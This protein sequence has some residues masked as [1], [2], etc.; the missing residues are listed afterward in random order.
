M[1]LVHPIDSP[2][3]GRRPCLTRGKPP[4][5]A[6]FERRP[7]ALWHF[8]KV[9]R[10]HPQ[11]TGPRKDTYPATQ[12]TG[13]PSQLS[14][15]ARLCRDLRLLTA[16][17]ELTTSTQLGISHQTNAGSVRKSSSVFLIRMHAMG[18]T[19][20]LAKRLASLKGYLALHVSIA[21]FTTQQGAFATCLGTSSGCRPTPRGSQYHFRRHSQKCCFKFYNMSK[22]VPNTQGQSAG[23][24]AKLASC[25]TA[26]HSLGVQGHRNTSTRLRRTCW[27]TN[28][29]GSPS[30]WLCSSGGCT[31]AQQRTGK[32]K[33]CWFP[34]CYLKVAR[35]HVRPRTLL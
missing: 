32:A 1:P 20:S 4:C 21:S 12:H 16:S 11:S 5:L 10:L 6:A 14:S 31:R 34:T 30:T 3:A 25:L 18:H 35:G 15:S 33:G 7:A 23:H 19:A 28:V 8:C 17:E 27:P 24:K 29:A 2:C 26:R 9:S 13:G 22:V